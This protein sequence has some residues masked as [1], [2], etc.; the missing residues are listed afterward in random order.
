[1]PSSPQSG[2]VAAAAAGTAAGTAAAATAG[3]GLGG[4]DEEAHGAGVHGGAFADGGPEFLHDAEGV[5]VLFNDEV[6][7][8][9][10][11]ESEADA[12]AAASA[13]GEIKTDT[14]LFLVGKEG[15]EFSTSAIS[16]GKHGVPP[17]GIK[18]GRR[19]PP[20]SIWK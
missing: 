20:Q 7:F 5:A 18:K 12:G 6:L 17:W 11:V 9:G 14:G 1:M 3:Q 13:R 19:M 2:L 4:S 16:K 15:V 10:F 8:A